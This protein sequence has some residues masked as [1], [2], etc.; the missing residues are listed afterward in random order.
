MT[1][2]EHALLIVAQLGTAK[3]Y[4]QADQILSAAE[5]NHQLLFKDILTSLQEKIENLSPLDCNSSQWSIYRY[6]LMC[7]HSMME[8]A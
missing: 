3:D 4:T 1:T 8:P 6:T 7:I 5:K 2:D